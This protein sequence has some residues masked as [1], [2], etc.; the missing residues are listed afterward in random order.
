MALFWALSL[1][2]GSIYMHGVTRLYFVL[3]VKLFAQASDHND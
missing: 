3:K 1:L 2:I